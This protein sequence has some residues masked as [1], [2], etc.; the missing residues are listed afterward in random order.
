M[1]VC[2]CVCVCV[3]AC[4]RACM[5]VCVCV[6]ERGV[7]VYICAMGASVHMHMCI[8]VRIRACVRACMRLNAFMF[9]HSGECAWVCKFLMTSQ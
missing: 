3:H 9:I 5:R 7:P 2:A 4:M 6:R 8:H 1:C